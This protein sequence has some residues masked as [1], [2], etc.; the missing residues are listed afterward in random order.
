MISFFFI[1]DK[2]ILTFQKFYFQ[3]V[4]NKEIEA[5]KLRDSKRRSGMVDSR[6]SE[7]FESILQRRKKLEREAEESQKSIDVE[8]KKQGIVNKI[9]QSIVSGKRVSSRQQGLDFSPDS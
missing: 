1:F 7:Y 2:K 9:I 8:W 5:V 4:A 6:S 3:T